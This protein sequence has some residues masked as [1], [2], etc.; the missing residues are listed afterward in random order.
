VI[1]HP[2]C[3]A[4]AWLL[5]LLVALPFT[6]PFSSCDISMLLGATPH[7]HRAR[8]W[9]TTDAATTSIDAAT[10][11]SAPGAVLEEEF[12]DAVITPA[13]IGSTTETR[14]GAR[15]RVVFHSSVTRPLLV[16]LRL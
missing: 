15:E 2:V 1:S 10:T 13:S 5:V 11:Q 4:S 3:G 9:S 12:K 6:A 14:S 8:A 16:A 7:H